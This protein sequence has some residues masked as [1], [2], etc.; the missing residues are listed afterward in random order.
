[1]YVWNDSA[2]YA[3][4]AGLTN[5]AWRVREMCAKVVAERSIACPEQLAEI[6]TDEV[7][8]VRAQ[9]ARALGVV[10]EASQRGI[11]KSLLKDPDIDVRRQAGTAL[12]AL[13]E[14]VGVEDAAAEAPAGESPA[15]AAQAATD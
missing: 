7:A 9:A 12:K 11:L 2:S 13:T 8:R 6:A 14:R 10:G 3:I 4:R 15:S 5:Q 1:L